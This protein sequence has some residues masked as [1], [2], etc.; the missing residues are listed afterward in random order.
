VFCLGGEFSQLGKNKIKIRKLKE[1]LILK[2]KFKGLF[3][4]IFEIKK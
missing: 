4:V 1:T 2:N 3:L